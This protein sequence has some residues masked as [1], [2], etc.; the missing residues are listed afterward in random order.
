MEDFHNPKI[1]SHSLD[2]DLSSTAFTD[3]I[4]DYLYQHVRLS[5]RLNNVLDLVI[6]SNVN[7]VNDIQVLEK[8]GN[9]DHNILVW[10][11]TCDKRLTKNKKNQ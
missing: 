6:S 2:Y 1:N 11:F 3:V 5:T 9:S 7:M 10:K 8:L 4:I